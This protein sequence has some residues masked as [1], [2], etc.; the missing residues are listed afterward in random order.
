MPLEIRLDDQFSS[1]MFSV[2]PIDFCISLFRINF[3][4][5]YRKSKLFLLL[6]KSF[7]KGE[8]VCIWHCQIPSMGRL[9]YVR[10]IMAW[11]WSETISSKT[12]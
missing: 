4:V 5:G 7:V 10:L 1:L 12:R 3:S 8:F 2:Q 9:T 11:T 6:L